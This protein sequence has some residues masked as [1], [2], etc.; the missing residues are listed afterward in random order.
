[1]HKIFFSY[2]LK[3][4]NVSKDF[5]LNL[6]L[7]TKNQGVDSYIDIL[8]NDYNE[9]EFQKKLESIL[10]KC[11][12]FCKIDS[13]LYDTS[14]WTKKEV[15]VAKQH[16]LNYFTYSPNELKKFLIQNYNVKSVFQIQQS[17]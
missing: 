16:K 10:R 2:T 8:D 14:K 6:R 7:W 5:L 3:D 11:D 9:K 1:M 17:S 15:Q 4:G 12:T 13:E